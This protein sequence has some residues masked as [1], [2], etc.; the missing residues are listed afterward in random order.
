MFLMVTAYGREEVLKEA[1]GAGIDNVLIKPV[2]ASILFDSTMNVL[3]G[4]AL[5]APAADSPHRIADHR[6]AAIRGARILLVEDNDVNQQVARELLEDAGL[7]VAVADDGQ[8]ALQMVQKYA[9]DLVFMDMQMPVMDGVTATREIRKL[10]QLAHLPVVAM[11]ANAMA[12]D[13]RKCMDAGMNDF[14]V[15]PIDPQEMLAILVRWVRPRQAAVVGAP[16][17]WPSQSV[18]GTSAAGL[19]GEFPEGIPGLDAKLGLSRMMGKKSLY[20]A[21]LRRYA[22]GQQ[23]VMQEMRD[24]LAAGNPQTAERVAHTTKAVS[25]TIGATLVQDRAAALEMAIRESRTA[26]EIEQLLD[27]LE[28]PLAELLAVLASRLPSEA[29]HA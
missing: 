2:S 28:G 17:G 14:L 13:R 9:Y 24:A 15:K 8:A 20:A 18:G 11:T 16:A 5:E 21:M 6:L 10:Q 7:A 22:V 23:A 3:G 19:D 29:A 27:E 4:R 1:E 25:G 12:Q 26:A